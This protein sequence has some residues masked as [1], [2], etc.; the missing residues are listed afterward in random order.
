MK[1]ILRD[2]GKRRPK[3][4]PDHIERRLRFALARFGERVERVV[5][6]LTDLNGPKG[7]VDKACRILVKVRGCSVAMALAVDSQW[8][9]AVDRATT[10]IGNKVSRELDRLR[11]HD[12]HHG[13]RLPLNVANHAAR[14]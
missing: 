5:V 8:K 3:D 14:A 10:R 2:A 11:Q 4:L 7:G 12:S 9:A 13:R 6:F 1:W